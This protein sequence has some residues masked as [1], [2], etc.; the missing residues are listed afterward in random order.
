[1]I[2]C[3]NLCELLNKENFDKIIGSNL[4]GKKTERIYF[5]SYFCSVYF[6]SLQFYREMIRLLK[7]K[8][9]RLTLVVP[10][11]TEKHLSGAKRMISDILAA[12][13]NYV[14]EVTV[15]DAGMLSYII[16]NYPGVTFNLGRLFCK[17]PRDIRSRDFSKTRTTPA[18]LS[19]SAGIVPVNGIIEIDETN[20]E[21][22]IHDSFSGRIGVHYPF[23]YLTTGN[24]CKFAGIHA[25]IDHKFR[26]NASC[27]LECQRIFE[28]YRDDLDEDTDGIFRIG[29]TVYFKR[30]LRAVVHAEIDRMIYFP[31]QETARITGEIYENTSSSEQ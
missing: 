5:G 21:L 31:F 30:K 12:E 10:V 13:D 14:D 23:C 15:N 16:Q 25:Q 28:C 22:D 11:F 18:L 24:I 7:Q 6:L 20:D 3:L 4:V 1:M 17:D 26:P 9:I 8:E 27:R 19:E 2:Y 29:R